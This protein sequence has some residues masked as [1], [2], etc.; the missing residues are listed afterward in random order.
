MQHFATL[1][2]G[3]QVFFDSSN[4]H[5]A[6]HIADTPGLS[7]LVSQYLVTQ[8][9]SEPT[10]YVDYD[11]GMKIGKSDLVETGEK[12]EIVYAKRMNRDTFTRFVIGREPVPCSYITVVLTMRDD[13]D[14][15]LSS[16]WIGRICP[17]FPDDPKATSTSLSFWAAHALVWG[18]QAVQGGTKTTQSPW[19]GEVLK[20][21]ERIC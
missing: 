18:K 8:S 14:Y 2:N 17:A 6:T 9:F 5:A 3:K 7:E 20:E 19:D 4:S 13:R 12:D 16:A 10:V 21:A 11:T 15:D 1:A